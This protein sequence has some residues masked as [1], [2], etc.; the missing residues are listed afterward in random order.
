MHK[1]TQAII[2]EIDSSVREQR[3]YGTFDFLADEPHEEVAVTLIYSTYD[4]ERGAIYILEIKSSKGNAS[5]VA[6][7]PSDG[8]ITFFKSHIKSSSEALMFEIE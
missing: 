2:D 4:E 7:T 8:G 5:F 3:N 1:Y 6:L